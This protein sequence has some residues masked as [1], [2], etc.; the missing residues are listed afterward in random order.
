MKQ[1]TRVIRQNDGRI[2]YERDYGRVIGTRGEKG[3]VTIYDPVKD[4]V[5]TSYPSH[6]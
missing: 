3:H 4:K 1:P 2:R 5:V 6:F